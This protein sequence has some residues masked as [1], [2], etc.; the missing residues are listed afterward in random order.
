MSTEAQKKRAD[1]VKN[2]LASWALEGYEPD[3]EYIALLDQYI[4]GQKT[5]TEILAINEAA[6]TEPEKVSNE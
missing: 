4:S 2:M 1:A 5:L 3:Q 6:F